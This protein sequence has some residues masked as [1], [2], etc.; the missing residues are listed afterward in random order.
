M[1]RWR[2]RDRRRNGPGGFFPGA[3]LDMNFAQSRYLGATPSSM[4]VTRASTG[5][6]EDQSGVWTSFGNNE[7]RITNKGLL[8]EEARTNSLRNNSMQGAVA[9]TPG[10]APTNWVNG[11][12]SSV[13]ISWRIAGVGTENGVE[14]VDIA[15]SGTVAGVLSGQVIYFDASINAAAATTGQTWTN[16]AFLKLVSGNLTGWTSLDLTLRENDSGPA[17]LRQTLSNVLTMGGTLTRF[18]HAVT[19]G[20]STAGIATGLRFSIADTTVVDATI[21]IGWPQLELGAFATS[22]IRTTSAAVTRAADAVS[23]T[24]TAF[25]SWY[26]APTAATIYAENFAQAPV[27]FATN[28]YIAAISDGTLNNRLSLFWPGT[29]LNLQG[30]ITSGGVAATPGVAGTT[31]PTNRVTKVALAAGVGANLGI[32]SYDAS[33][34]TASTPAAFPVGCN[35]MTLGQQEVGAA[36]FL[37]GYLRRIAYFPSRLA[38]AEL[39][40]ITT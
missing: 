31:S 18:S 28:Q 3:T 23:L 34:G 37:N 10:T 27:S 13:G 20:A 26:G 6:A 22:P 39:Q 1:L 15:F 11:T 19:M 24:G 4:T 5:Y 30:R 12:G 32:A 40:A 7:P 21:R 35:V 29:A 2:A 25:S 16:S 9:G 33:L 36:Q 38:N 14:Y 8:V 17:F